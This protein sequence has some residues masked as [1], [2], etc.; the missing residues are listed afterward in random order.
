MSEGEKKDTKKGGA[1]KKGKRK[2]VF[3]DDVHNLWCWAVRKE[4]KVRRWDVYF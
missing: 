4:K 2:F 1:G 3:D